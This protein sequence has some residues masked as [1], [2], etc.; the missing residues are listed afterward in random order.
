MN[1][2]GDRPNLLFLVWIRNKHALFL[3]NHKLNKQ[4][5]YRKLIIALT[6][7]QTINLSDGVFI[8]W[9]INGKNHRDVGPAWIEGISNENPNGTEHYYYQH[10]ELH[11]D[12]GPAI[13]QGISNENPNGIYHAYHKQGKRHR[14]NGPSIIT[15]I[16]NENPNGG[17]HI[18]YQ[19]GKRHRDDGPAWI[20]GISKENPNGIYHKY[21]LNG[22]NVEPF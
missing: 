11:H 2:L 17:E 4:L 21:Y 6:T 18:Y 12:D 1:T 14:D 16:S 5:Y 22:V 20:G 7:K 13:I 10:G 3:L 9:K 8:T 15:G 19:H